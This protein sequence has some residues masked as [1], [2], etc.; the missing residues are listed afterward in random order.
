[1]TN[2]ITK[3]I[4]F[5]VDE[6]GNLVG[7]HNPISQNSSNSKYADRTIITSG[8]DGTIKANLIPRTGDK[9]TL[10]AL[11][12]GGG[13]IC[14]ATKD[15]I[16]DNNQIV[17]LTGIA[18]NG[19]AT[20]IGATPLYDPTSQVLFGVNSI[21]QLSGSETTSMGN[22][23]IQS[24]TDPFTYNGNDLILASALG[25]SNG[26]LKLATPTDP[27]GSS[28]WGVAV[29]SNAS[30]ATQVGFFDHAPVVKPTVAGDTLANLLIALRS[31]GLIV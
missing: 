30:G 14:V 8:A 31:L 11:K 13:E 6:F 29:T 16:F 21:T 26:Q 3:N 20:V 4:D 9:A 22:M 7:S 1:M 10:M 5:I 23:V 12:S 2:S 27:S 15:G 24:N 17:L 18:P 19:V 25:T 28:V